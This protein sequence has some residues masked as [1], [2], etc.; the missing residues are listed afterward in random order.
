MNGKTPAYEGTTGPVKTVTLKN[1][2]TLSLTSSTDMFA[3]DGDDRQF[4]LK[5]LEE[6]EAYEK[7][8][9]ITEAENR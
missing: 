7:G 1:G 3:M 5:L 2:V 6:M 9:Q 4:V 8:L